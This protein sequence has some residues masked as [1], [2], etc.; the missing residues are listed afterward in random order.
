MA[1]APVSNA[2]VEVRLG[3]IVEDALAWLYRAEERPLVVFMGTDELDSSVDVTMTLTEAQAQEV[4]RTDLLEAGHEVMLVVAKGD[5]PAPLVKVERAYAGTPNEGIHPVQSVLL[6]NPRWKRHDVW[7]AMIHGL[8]GTIGGAVP[9][10]KQAVIQVTGEWVVELPVEAL[11][12]Q[13]VGVKSGDFDRVRWVDDWEYI[14]DHPASTTGQGID[15]STV[16]LNTYSEVVVRYV[17]AYPTKGPFDTEWDETELPQ[18][19]DGESYLVELWVGTA[20]VVALY[21]AAMRLTGREMSRIDVTEMEQ[22]NSDNAQ[23]Y[24]V[25]VTAAKFM[26]QTFYQRL[27]E[28]RR[29]HAGTFDK[30]RPYKRRINVRHFGDGGRLY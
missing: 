28:L 20:D 5:E 22:W 21:A 23:R 18:S 1:I 7:R 19:Q 11:D 30:H 15:L 17:V 24:N 27:D 12:V 10:T 3:D 25:N 4:H 29:Q 2:K 16:I 6:K 26:W 9:M 14:R 13:R 8:M